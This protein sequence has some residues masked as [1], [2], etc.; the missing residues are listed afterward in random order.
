MLMTTKRNRDILEL[1]PVSA[2]NLNKISGSLVQKA[3][4]M[5]RANQGR[6]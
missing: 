2:H 1:V 6:C 4:D 5:P 3:E